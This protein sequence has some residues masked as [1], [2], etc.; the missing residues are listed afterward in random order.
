M[1]DATISDDVASAIVSSDALPPTTKKRKTCGRCLRPAP[2]CVCDHL[3][4]VPIELRAT[5]ILILQHAKE[6]SRAHISTVPLI[7]LCVKQCEVLV[8]E[9]FAN[10]ERFQVR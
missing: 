4:V 1:S 7:R 2:V 3:P 6:A 10:N 9:D 8:G 5:S